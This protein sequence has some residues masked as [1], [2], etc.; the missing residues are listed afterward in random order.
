MASELETYLT[1][2]EVSA[3]VRKNPVT[4]RRHRAHLRTVGFGRG[5][6]V[7]LDALNRFIARVYPTVDLLTP[8]SLVIWR[9][10]MKPQWME[11]ITYTQTAHLIIKGR[12]ACGAKIPKFA[13]WMAATTFQPKCKRCLACQ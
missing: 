12:S 5:Q 4:I 3:Y 13:A 6:R 2:A 1:L 8:E 11:C 10:T 9:A 7:R